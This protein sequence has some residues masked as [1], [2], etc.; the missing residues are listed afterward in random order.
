M[1]DSDCLPAEDSQ[2]TAPGR[3]SPFTLLA[4]H[5]CR[6]AHAA[7]GERAALARMNPRAPMPHQLAALSRAVIAAGLTPESW[8][9]EHWLGWTLIA[10]GMALAGHDA[11]AMLGEQLARAG[12]AES[13]VSRLLTARGEAF[14]Q[15]LP[16]LLRLMASKGVAPNWNELGALVLRESGNGP[17]DRQQVET[18]RLRIA[19]RYFSALAR[20]S[21]N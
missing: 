14:V 10:H 6:I 18:L 20:A 21:R 15:T 16:R 7:P 19:G 2:D 13:R 1:T 17:V 5:L 3:A 4:A 8:A 11:S 12:V 9:R